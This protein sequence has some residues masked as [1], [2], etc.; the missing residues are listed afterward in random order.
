LKKKENK[1]RP[2]RSEG[3]KKR[4]DKE[5]KEQRSEGTKK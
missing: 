1:K 2:Q 3:T 5:V 4:R